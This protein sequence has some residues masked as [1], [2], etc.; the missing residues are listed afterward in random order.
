MLPRFDILCVVRDVVDPIQDQRLAE[1]VVGSHAASHPDE[2][3]AAEGE[4]DDRQQQ[5]RQQEQQQG[6]LPQ[7]LLRKYITYAKQNCRPVFGEVSGGMQGIGS[8][9]L[10]DLSCLHYQ[11]VHQ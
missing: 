11:L 9:E 10:T 2:M 8:R 7:E 5:R 3:A 1:F 4:E 6:I